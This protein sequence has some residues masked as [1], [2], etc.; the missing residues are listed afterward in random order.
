MFALEGSW[1]Y[2]GATGFFWGQR[3]LLSVV[4]GPEV[5]QALQERCAEASL[6]EC[7]NQNRPEKAAG[8]FLAVNLHPAEAI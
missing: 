6:L 2:L 1:K 8:P 5:L 7:I 3:V 4:G